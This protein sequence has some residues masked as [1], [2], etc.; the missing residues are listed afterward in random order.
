MVVKMKGAPVNINIIDAYAPTLSSTRVDLDIFY[1]DLNKAM[2]ICKH[3][4][5]KTVL[6]DFNAKL[7]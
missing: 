3:S 6:G 4:E 5:M 7:W 1:D 2:S